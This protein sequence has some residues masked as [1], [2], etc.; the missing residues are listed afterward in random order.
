LTSSCVDIITV[1][2][3]LLAK[4]RFSSTNA[5]CSEMPSDRARYPH[6]SVTI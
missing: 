5:F 3:L 2:S 6:C 1:V 4:H